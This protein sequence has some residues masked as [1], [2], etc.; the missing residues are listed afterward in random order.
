MLRS[1]IVIAGK[2]PALIDGGGE[3]TFVLMGAPRC[4]LDTSRIISASVPAT[5]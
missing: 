5:T 3:S 2:D 4:A 1:I